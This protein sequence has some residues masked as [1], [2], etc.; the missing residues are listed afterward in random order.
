[1]G[2]P[3][4]PQ[5]P[6]ESDQ[7]ILNIVREY[8][9]E[10]E[11]AFKSRRLRNR[12]NYDVYLGNVDW[13]YKQEGQSTE[14]L[15]KLAGAAEQMAAFAK[16]ALVQ[17]GDWFSME[18]PPEAP[19]NPE[20]ARKL[21]QRFLQSII[22]GRGAPIDI[23]TLIGDA[24]KQGLLESLIILKVHGHNMTQRSFRVEGGDVIAG[25][26][27]KLV[28]E[29]DT[30][31]RL[32]IDLVP[33]EDYFPDPTGRGLYEIHRVERD[34]LDVLEMAEDGIYDMKVVEQLDNDFAERDRAEKRLPRTK[35]QDESKSP[36][37]RRRVQVDEMWGTLLG[38]DGRPLKGKDGKPLV[39]IVTTIANDKH[40]LRQPE[41][42]PLWHQ[43]SPFVAAPVIRVPHSVVGKALYDH[44]AELNLA[45]SEYYNLI[46][47]GGIA[48]V[49]GV[50]QVRS[51][52]LE[53][54]R[55]ISNG[56]PQNA[57]LLVSSETPPDGKVVET[58]AT[59][60]VPPEALQVFNLTD[61]EFQAASLTNDT[62]LGNLPQRQVKA[63][64]LIQ[65]EQSAGVI[66][67]SFAGDIER[68]IIAPAL[69][70]AWLTMMQFA[71]D[72]PAQDVVDAIGT[73][74]AFRLSRMSPEQRFAAFS[75]PSMVVNGLSGTLSRA[76]EF[77]KLMAMLQGVTVNPV[78]M[79]AFVR[80]VSGD[81]ALD[82]VLRSLNINPESLMPTE[83][84]EAE[85]PE[86]MDR[87]QALTQMSPAGGKGSPAKPEGG[88]DAV[89]ETRSEINQAAEPT[90]GMG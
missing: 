68:S 16:R 52:W 7:N 20:Q 33:S 44:A 42:N 71:D 76:R 58:V 54:P 74:A 32:R 53:D 39:N 88:G 55:Q 25:V 49:W 28:A 9:A 38:P 82:H 8:R 77:Q 26:A 4:K 43:E 21:L 83:E 72:I 79:E 37:R 56:I 41:S 17:F 80:R 69:R 61:R 12:Q 66:V 14:F 57:T 47:D 30:V 22:V 67:D 6:S 70:K 78:L 11:Q 18:L 3:R 19:M 35:A 50:R 51:E 31:W 65:A 84:E 59:G 85:M 15:P 86:R 10:S 64:E 5:G 89:S 2:R 1:M 62:R 46:L 75:R 29:D 23:A 48:S 40:I 45:L 90:G 13:S 36:A 27:P 60:K 87:M 34:F 24:V 81:K 73:A 63:T